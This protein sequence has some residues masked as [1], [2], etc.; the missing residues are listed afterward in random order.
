MRLDAF[1]YATKKL[2]T[3]CF[4]EEPE[5]WDLLKWIGQIMDKFGVQLLAE[6][7]EHYTIQLNL[8]R[9]NHG[10][11]W[12]FFFIFYFLFFCVTIYETTCV[13]TCI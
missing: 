8:A 4:M 13:Y 3:R 5:V 6:I 10:K 1:G 9:Q 2:G 12:V 7:H 11:Y